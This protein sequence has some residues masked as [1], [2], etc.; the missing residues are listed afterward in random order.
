MQTYIFTWRTHSKINLIGGQVVLS[1]HWQWFTHP[2]LSTLIHRRRKQISNASWKTSGS[3]KQ[4]IVRELA[5]LSCYALKSTK[6]SLNMGERRQREHFTTF[7]SEQLSSKNRRRF[8]H[9][10]L[11]SERLK[12]ILSPK[13]KV[14]VHIDSTG[15]ADPIPFGLSGPLVRIRVQLLAGG[16]CRYA[17]SASDPANET[18]EDIVQTERVPSRVV[19]TSQSLLPV[20]LLLA[21]WMLQKPSSSIWSVPVQN[22]KELCTIHTHNQIQGSNIW[23]GCHIEGPLQFE[24]GIFYGGFPRGFHQ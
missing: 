16:L 1:V 9:S 15:M 3:S 21:L 4:R 19:Q 13:T 10:V 17:V 12:L 7:I 2:H 14:V 6:S 5:S 22:R 23:T 11:S 18:E 20:P 24:T 8:V